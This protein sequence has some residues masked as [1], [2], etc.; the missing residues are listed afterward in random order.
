MNFEFC[1]MWGIYL[2]ILKLLSSVGLG[3]VD[4]EPAHTI[5]TLVLGKS[6]LTLTDFG[7]HKPNRLSE[8]QRR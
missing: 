4:L 1:T 8:P 5:G 3:Y 7:T 6:K 2:L